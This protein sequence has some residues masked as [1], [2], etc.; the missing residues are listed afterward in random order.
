M[1]CDYRFT[2]QTVWET[3]VQLSRR[4][5]LQVLVLFVRIWVGVGILREVKCEHLADD[6][7]SL[8]WAEE[9]EHHSVQKPIYSTISRVGHLVFIGRFVPDSDQIGHV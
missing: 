6:A 5:V 3:I 7:I 8:L 2:I 9:K 1:I 4:P